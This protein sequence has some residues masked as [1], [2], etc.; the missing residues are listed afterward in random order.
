MLMTNT[1][2]SNGDDAYFLVNIAGGDTTVVDAIGDFGPDPGSGF[3]VAGVTNGTQ[4]HTIVRKSSVLTGNGGDWVTSAGTNSEDSEWIV[5][6]SDDW[7][8]LGT[9]DFEGCDSAA[10]SSCG[11]PV[12]YQGYDYATV[13]I[14]DQCWFAENL[15]SENYANGD[16]IPTL[17]NSEWY[18][19]TS[20]AVAVYNGDSASLEAYGRL[21]NWYAVDDVRD[22]CPNGWHIPTDGEWMTMEMA[23][24]M[25]EAETTSFGLRGTDQGAQMKTDYG[26]NN[27]NGSN[28][29]GFSG[30]PGGNRSP[31]GNF[32]NLPLFG[33][34][35]SSSLLDVENGL[36]RFLSLN[37][38]EVGRN[39]S[40][41]RGGKS[42]RCIQ[43]PE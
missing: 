39:F 3:T 40:A 20:G 9:H 28:A 6:P 27:G 4:N 19:A 5:L 22:L 23:L 21:Y 1:N 38:D 24:G 29:S 33:F 2:Y 8:S 11:I 25:I 32:Y 12:N 35:W 14:G 17:N 13:L 36:Y 34:W 18:T 43:D 7:T 37:Y 16:V 15:R 10:D 41:L 42:V 31:N 26:W 30:L